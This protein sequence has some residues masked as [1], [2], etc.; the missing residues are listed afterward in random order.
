MRVKN[1]PAKRSLPYPFLL[2]LSI[3]TRAERGQ[4]PVEKIRKKSQ[5]ERHEVFEKSPRSL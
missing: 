5:D 4:N 2:V 3:P 1:S